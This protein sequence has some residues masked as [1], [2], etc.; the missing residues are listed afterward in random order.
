MSLYH[1]CAY[2]WKEMN[3]F[4]DSQ[5]GSPQS[6]AKQ[7]K[8]ENI[9]DCQATPRMITSAWLEPLH[10]PSPMP[11]SH[12]ASTHHECACE[13]KE[14]NGLEDSQVGTPQRR[15]KQGKAE[16][17]IDC[18]ATRMIISVWLERQ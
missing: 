1:R 3:G 15:A 8:A 12:S 9:M 5:A 11:L 10:F 17:T 16:D 4:E 18:Q 6:R 14:M 2:E 13:W 7:G